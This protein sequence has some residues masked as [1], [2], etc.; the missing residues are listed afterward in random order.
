MSINEM[1]FYSC[2]NDTLSIH[3]Y[4]APVELF[5]TDMTNDFFCFE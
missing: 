1:L 2:D 4:F 5:N 3:V